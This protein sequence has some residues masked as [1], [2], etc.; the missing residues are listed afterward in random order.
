MVKQLIQAQN[1]ELHH[2]C[3]QPEVCMLLHKS[4]SSV[5]HVGKTV[6]TLCLG[7]F[8]II[9]LGKSEGQNALKNIF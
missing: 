3:I 5:K 9:S 4:F 8:L 6:I 7:S 1:S 2:G